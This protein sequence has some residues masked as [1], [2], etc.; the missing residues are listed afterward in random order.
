MAVEGGDTHDIERREYIANESDGECNSFDGGG[1]R[2]QWTWAK[3][4]CGRIYAPCAQPTT[5]DF[6][7]S[8][9]AP[10]KVTFPAVSPESYCNACHVSLYSGKSQ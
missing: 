10:K 5:S 1:D 7:A 2:A 8:T 6:T 3:P 9:C 4:D